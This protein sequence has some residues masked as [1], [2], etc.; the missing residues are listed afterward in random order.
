MAIG[1][2]VEGVP[3]VDR[4][5]HLAGQQVDK[6]LGRRRLD[7]SGCTFGWYNPC[8][9]RTHLTACQRARAIFAGLAFAI[10]TYSSEKT[11]RTGSGIPGNLRREASDHGPAPRATD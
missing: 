11:A 7:E 1:D 4:G 9:R 3:P 5:G 2:V 8:G 6:R 10:A